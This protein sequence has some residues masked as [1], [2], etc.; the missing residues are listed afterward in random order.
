MTDLKPGKTEFIG[1]STLVHSGPVQ[2][3][4]YP[5]VGVRHFGDSFGGPEIVLLLWWGGGGGGEGGRGG[6]ESP[7]GRG[8]S[9]LF[10]TEIPL[11]SNREDFLFPGGTGGGGGAG[12]S[13]GGAEGG[14]KNYSFYSNIELVE[15]L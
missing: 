6:V 4:P 12:G 10:R 9:G 11:L 7:G 8:G 3:R 2:S 5:E 15:A 14:V 1:L 13:T